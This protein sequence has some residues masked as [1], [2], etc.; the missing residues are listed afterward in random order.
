MNVYLLCPAIGT[1]LGG[2]APGVALLL[3]ALS[4]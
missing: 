2:L 3:R 1:Y 4:T